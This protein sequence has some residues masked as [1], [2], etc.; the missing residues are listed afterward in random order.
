M[1]DS[2]V[3]PV[4]VEPFEGSVSIEAAIDAFME[5]DHPAI[6]ESSLR[7]ERWGRFSILACD[8]IDQYRSA[9]D[10]KGDP[11][12]QF[13]ER[14]RAFARPGSSVENPL[15]FAGGWIGY[16]TYE[17]SGIGDLWHGRGTGLR[18]AASL[19]AACFHLYDSAAVYDHVRQQWFL[20]AAAV[21]ADAR[22]LDRRRTRI[23][24]LRSLLEA[25]GRSCSTPEVP[26]S[27]VCPDSESGIL[28]NV[29][30]SLA[31]S[32]YR[33]AVQAV[34]DFIAAGD[35]YQVN[36]AQRFTLR[37]ELDPL[38]LYIRMRRISPS[39]YG[40]FLPW[41]DAAILSASPE[42]FLELRSGQVISRPIKGTRPRGRNVVED[43]RLRRELRTSDKDRAELAMIVDLLRN[44]L[45][46][47]ADVGSVRVV[48]PSEI[49][50]HPTVFHGV[51]TIAATLDTGR[52]WLDLLRA[53]F[54][55]G[56]VT[57]VP[58]T[59]AVKLI[60]ELEPVARGVYC[61]AV[62]LIGIDDSL[63]LNLPIRTLVQQGSRVDLFA[64]S[65]IVAD[66][67]PEGEWQEVLA[68]AAGLLHA[69]RGKPLPTGRA[70]LGVG[71]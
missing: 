59:R 17:S 53:T 54:P 50:I 43:A 30:W 52:T 63:T 68:K 41:G 48:E 35:A 29:E 56:S 18:R 70:R 32:E 27:T 65:G 22:G 14:S 45:G 5:T 39:Y 37:T 51:A 28:E 24:R 16:F 15:P 25:A 13:F 10:E 42:L 66:S 21:E 4:A 69:V 34:L 2:S 12:V 23:E 58:K 1:Q 36:I 40:A 38:A 47:V 64:G 55:G 26:F 11:F 8:P 60:R 6:L 20:V 62:G 67:S 19:P 71:A 3:Q 49:E 57:G 46:R 9:H 61:G 31:P 7:H 44:D 33:R